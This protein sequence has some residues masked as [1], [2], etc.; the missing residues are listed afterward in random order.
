MRAKETWERASREVKEKR[1]EDLLLSL[2]VNVERWF[3]VKKRWEKE[4]GWAENE[5][6]DR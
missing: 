3:V 4:K 1:V 5:K 6:R 2:S